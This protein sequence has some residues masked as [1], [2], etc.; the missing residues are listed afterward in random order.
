MIADQVRGETTGQDIAPAE[1]THRWIRWVQGHR[2]Q[3]T[4]QAQGILRAIVDN[5]PVEEAVG[6]FRV[7]VVTE[8]IGLG[9]VTELNPEIKGRTQT[10]GFRTTP[11]LGKFVARIGAVLGG[12]TPQQLEINSIIRLVASDQLL[13]VCPFQAEIGEPV[14]GQ[15]QTNIG[16]NLEIIFAL[17]VLPVLRLDATALAGIIENKV[18]HA[19]N[20]IRTVLGRG[21]ISQHLDIL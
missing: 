3:S 18:D 5:F 15:R 9:A 14:V 17:V 12:R 7:G 6:A 1:V 8:Q 11:G 19:R 10:G 21:A 20:G 2:L 13:I 4:V 16:R